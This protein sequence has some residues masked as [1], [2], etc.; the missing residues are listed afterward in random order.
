M[1]FLSRKGQIGNSWVFASQEAKLRILLRY[2]TPPFKLQ[3]CK[4]IKYQLSL[5]SG[6]QI[7]S[8]GQSLPTS[9]LN[10]QMMILKFSPQLVAKYQELS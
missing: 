5:Q 7:W 6:D 8:P 9:D 4:S 1:L 10:E 3:P 2:L